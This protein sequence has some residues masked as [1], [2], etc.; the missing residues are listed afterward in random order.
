MCGYIRVSTDA[1]GD[2]EV[3]GPMKLE[4]QGVVSSST[5]VLETKLGPS[6]RGSSAVNY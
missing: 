3:S 2:P 5:W 6:A 1:S 4:L